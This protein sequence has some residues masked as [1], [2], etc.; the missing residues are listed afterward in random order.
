MDD[1]TRFLILSLEGENY[2]IPI[3]RLMEIMV[4]R[5]IQKDPKLTELFEGTFEFR[6]TS[7]PVLNLKKIFKLSG[8]PGE[9]LLVIKN[10]RGML[11][12]L[13]EAVM[14]ILDT[15]QRL[16]PLPNGVINPSLQYYKGI[17]RHK[18]NLVLLLN[19]DELLP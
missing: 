3:T 14:D 17:L 1:G 10:A 11:G 5:N 4:A 15:E 13:V 8:H 19:E 16:I 6:G 12:I 2:A 18:E 9:T 7:I